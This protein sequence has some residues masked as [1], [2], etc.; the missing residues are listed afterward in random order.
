MSENAAKL[1][2]PSNNVGHE[3]IPGGVKKVKTENR[4]SD[5]MFYVDPSKIRVMADFNVR[6]R[7]E[8]YLAHL[9]GIADSMLADG[10]NNAYPLSV[11][12]SKEGDEDVLNLVAGHTRLEASA[13]A[14]AEGAQFDTVPVVILP[15]T[16]TMIDMTVD[17]VRGNS[18]RPL[19]LLETS[20]VVARL[21]KLEL[22]DAE[23]GRR[24]GMTETHVKNMV[25]LAAAPT[26]VKKMVASNEISASLAISMIRKHGS[27]VVDVLN[28]ARKASKDAGKTKLTASHLPNAVREKAQRKAAP[29]LF[30]IA[31]DLRSDPQYSALSAELRQRLEELLAGIGNE[32]AETVH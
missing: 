10:F 7:D 17:L 3:L 22:S 5:A 19:T 4:R 11:Y 6:V 32:G 20:A 27:N 21:E 15:K 9:R 23:I 8:S 18:G 2:I 14:I 25:L 31:D 13:L 16:T 30:Q 12:I 24:L 1:V 28:A 29:R 26:A